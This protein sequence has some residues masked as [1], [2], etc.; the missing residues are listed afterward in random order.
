MIFRLLYDWQ[1]E[2]SKNRLRRRHSVGN[3]EKRFVHTHRGPAQVSSLHISLLLVA[4]NNSAHFQFHSSTN[5]P[6]RPQKKVESF[7]FLPSSPFS[8]LEM[9]FI[10]EIMRWWAGRAQHVMKSDEID[11]FIWVNWKNSSKLRNKMNCI[12]CHFY[13]VAVNLSINGSNSSDLTS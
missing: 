6:S 10:H 9:R 5:Y 4:D 3:C 13:S 2:K 12:N 11:S 7:N 8:R 1:V